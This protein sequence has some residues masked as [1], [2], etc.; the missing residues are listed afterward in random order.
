MNITR[1]DK[2]MDE[3]I[4]EIYKL[5]KEAIQGNE[6]A[7]HVL[8]DLK[9]FE[10]PKAR[11]LFFNF[12]DTSGIL[13][14]KPYQEFEQILR[15]QCPNHTLHLDKFRDIINNLEG[16]TLSVILHKDY[17]DDVT[18]DQ[19]SI[20]K[21][22][23]YLNHRIECVRLILFDIAINLSYFTSNGYHDILEKALIGT[24][25]LRPF[26]VGNV[27]L[28]LLNPS[29]IK[30]DGYIRTCPLYLSVL[31]NKFKFLGFPYM[32]QDYTIMTCSET[33]SYL[34]IYYFGNNYPEYRVWMPSEIY[35]VLKSVSENRIVPSSG[36]DI[37][38]IQKLL[39]KAKLSPI[40][41][42][43]ND[44]TSF[45]RIL[46][47]YIESGV[48]V[49]VTLS[50]HIVIAIGHTNQFQNESEAREKI[51]LHVERLK[52]DGKKL[53]I[54]NGA[55]IHDEYIFMDDN[56]APY[57]SFKVDDLYKEHKNK[58]KNS[59]AK[60]ISSI[61]YKK[62]LEAKRDDL[63]LVVP[64]YNR[65]LLTVEEMQ[66][67]AKQIFRR[68]PRIINDLLTQYYKEDPTWGTK[69]E[70]PIYYRIYI[71][72]SSSY[73]KCKIDNSTTEDDYSKHYLSGKHPRFIWV[74]E[75][76]SI[77]DH[78]Q[79]KARAEFLFDSTYA[80]HGIDGGLISF[81]YQGRY[82]YVPE[83]LDGFFKEY[84]SSTSSFT[85]P[86]RRGERTLI[87]PELLEYLDN[88]FQ[89][90]GISHKFNGPFS[91][92]IKYLTG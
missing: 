4:I 2:N 10:N 59:K 33:A 88:N 81:A 79:G 9:K 90:E 37:R 91:V 18:R 68:A 76:S 84:S 70:N 20:Y 42:E 25:I 26:R 52:L 14:S 44:K 66:I 30:V 60:F 7:K 43:F 48:P 45:N 12:Q 62:D 39:V 61:Q 40:R 34:M 41:Y 55:D 32:E 6:E 82:I 69:I 46:Y 77:S 65:I 5:E 67:A 54:V 15:V 8:E 78:L 1:R 27:G 74:I 19:I 58:Q 29:K 31:G 73:K 92:S 22:H 36:H 86:S 64:L 16:K 57:C 80:Q 71:A 87:T 51:N 38:N 35:E 3:S 23:S 47:T 72:N 49:M 85:T 53:Y 56:H 63:E 50:D 83:L 17:K 89:K 13:R 24:I 75:L 11:F 21:A 28:S